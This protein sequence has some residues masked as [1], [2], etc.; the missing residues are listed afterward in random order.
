M[1][2][3][4]DV[5]GRVC[6]AYDVWR[7]REISGEK[8]MGIERSTFVI[9]AAGHLVLILRGVDPVAHIEEVEAY[10]RVNLQA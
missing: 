5:D 9:D 7:E 1:P 3:L 2:L 4:A 8:R 6:E 10:I